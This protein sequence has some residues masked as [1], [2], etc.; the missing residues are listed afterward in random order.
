MKE[1]HLR[2]KLEINILMISGIILLF[3]ILLYNQFCI[4]KYVFHIP[5]TLCGIT[6]GLKSIISLNILDSFKYNLLSL[7][8]LIIILTFYILYFI[9]LLFNKKYINC[10]YNYFVLH[11]KTII[12]ILLI[13]WIINIL[14]GL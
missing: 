4:F 7:P 6:R 10:Y 2:T 8:I 3:I 11:Y 12:Y 1:I 13:N 5:F 9:S 14:R